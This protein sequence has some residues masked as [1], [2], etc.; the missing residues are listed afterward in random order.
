MKYSLKDVT[1]SFCVCIVCFS[2]SLSDNG[3]KARMGLRSDNTMVCV[4][5]LHNSCLIAKLVLNFS[6]SCFRETFLRNHK[7]NYEASL[8]QKFSVFSFM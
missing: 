8:K 1:N 4:L 5:H 3:Q 7:D 6:S 2:S